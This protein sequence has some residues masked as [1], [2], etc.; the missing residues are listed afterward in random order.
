[1]SNLT[2]KQ[3]EAAVKS[4][5]NDNLPGE[6]RYALMLNGSWE[7]AKPILSKKISCNPILEKES[8]FRGYMSP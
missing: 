8:P 6:Y 5:I 2:I 1:M 7:A 3:M 4:Y